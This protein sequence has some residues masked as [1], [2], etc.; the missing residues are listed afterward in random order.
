MKIAVIG[1]RDFE[2]Y[3]MMK[4]EVI[5]FIIKENLDKTNVIIVSGG[6]RGAD[7][8]AERLSKEMNWDLF[9]FR[10][11]WR[12]NGI[13]DNSAGYKRNKTIIDNSDAVIAFRIK[14]SKGTTHS[15]ELAKNKGIKV[16]TIDL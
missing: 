4:K 13:Y 10:A 16:R 14:N 15:I 1:S 9:V 7:S 8:L 5:D 2:D 6:A 12:Q 3:D 11:K